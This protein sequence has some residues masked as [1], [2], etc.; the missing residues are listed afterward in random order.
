MPKRVYKSWRRAPCRPISNVTEGSYS[1]RQPRERWHK[2]TTT[3]E[4]GQGADNRAIVC[5]VE[6]GVA[7][8]ALT[9]E[10]AADALEENEVMESSARASNLPA[11]AAELYSQS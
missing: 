9:P 10:C 5:R 11:L 2:R 3:G 4:S 7:A 1:P 8:R 6:I